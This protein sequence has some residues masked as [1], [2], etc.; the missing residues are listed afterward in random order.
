MLFVLF[1]FGKIRNSWMSKNSR[2]CAASQIQHK[3]SSIFELIN[4]RTLNFLYRN[5]NL[6]TFLHTTENPTYFNNYRLFR[7]ILRLYCI[8]YTLKYSAAPQFSRERNTWNNTSHKLWN[9]DLLKYATG[10][11]VVVNY[12]NLIHIKDSFCYGHI[13]ILYGPYKVK[14]VWCS[15]FR[16]EYSVV[17]A[18]WSF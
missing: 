16:V 1:L 10:K 9:T 6:S 2:T 3:P 15:S 11:V 5:C 13:T 12:I 7:L 8:A 4:F 14:V 18:R 17:K